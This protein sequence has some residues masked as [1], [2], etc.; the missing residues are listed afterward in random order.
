MAE[1]HSLTIPGFS[2]TNRMSYGSEILATLKQVGMFSKI[3]TANYLI[4]GFAGQDLQLLFLDCCCAGH[5]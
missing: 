1:L 2:R 4:G 5:S 3:H